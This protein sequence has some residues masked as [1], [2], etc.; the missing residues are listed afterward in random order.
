[1]LTDAGRAHQ[2]EIMKTIGQG[3]VV[4]EGEHEQELGP[5]RLG[6]PCAEEAGDRKW[7]VQ[8]L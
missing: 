2:G 7:A 5:R 4:S 3:D 8:G 1:M 6:D